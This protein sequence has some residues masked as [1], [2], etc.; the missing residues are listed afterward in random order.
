[1]RLLHL[2]VAGG[3]ICFASC[4]KQQFVI[5]NDFRGEIRIWKDPSAS[6]VLSPHGGTLIVTV[7]MDGRLLVRDDQPLCGA[8]STSARFVSGSRLTCD[9]LP[10][11]RVK[12]GEVAFWELGSASGN[13]YEGDPTHVYFVGTKAEAKKAWG[14]R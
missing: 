11:D 4:S 14:I 13:N 7:P 3:F 8:H 2:I 1:M 9:L 10:A 5:P 6:V 12:E